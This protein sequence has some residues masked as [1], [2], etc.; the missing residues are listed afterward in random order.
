MPMAHGLVIPSR[1]PVLQEHS[2]CPPYVNSEAKAQAQREE[3][4][5]AYKT[6]ITRAQ[7]ARKKPSADMDPVE[8]QRK[9]QASVD[10]PKSNL[11]DSGIFSQS[12]LQ[13]G[14]PVSVPSIFPIHASVS[15]VSQ[16]RPA[17]PSQSSMN[18]LIATMGALYNPGFPNVMHSAP[19]G[20]N[21]MN[22]QIKPPHQPPITNSMLSS[23]WNQ[24]PYQAP[25]R[26][27]FQEQS[28]YHLPNSTKLPTDQDV[29]YKPEQFLMEQ[30][31]HQVSCKSRLIVLF[32]FRLYSICFCLQA[33][34]KNGY[35]GQGVQSL[36]S[37]D[38]LERIDRSHEEPHRPPYT[39]TIGNSRA[40]DNAPFHTTPPRQLS[41]GV[42]RFDNDLPS[43]DPV[44]PSHPH[45]VVNGPRLRIAAHADGTRT[46]FTPPVVSVPSTSESVSTQPQQQHPHI[47]PLMELDLS[48]K[49]SEKDFG[50]F[51]PPIARGEFHKS[52][53]S[54]R[55]GSHPI[56]RKFSPVLST[57]NSYP[58]I[59]G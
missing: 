13:A 42:N 1:D 38:S 19:N 51:P 12:I 39:T 43:C 16:Q 7:M 4:T 58:T 30:F 8:V 47:T 28:V 34:S 25:A 14:A 20:G 23:S 18:P 29:F 33:G 2:H 45:T 24:S 37:G 10:S 32:I 46:A 15:H 57:I 44:I 56:N 3:R 21:Q 27:T 52:W 36:P 5:L 9:D 50:S 22:S 48:G 53:K 59:I 26:P 11:A 31:A 6:A 35:S 49:W 40:V 41:E 17:P 54:A 55:G